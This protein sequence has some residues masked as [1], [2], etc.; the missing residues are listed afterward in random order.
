MSKIRVLLADDHTVLRDGLRSMIDRQPD[1]TVVAEASDARAAVTSCEQTDA[2]VAVLDLAMPE[3][4]G[5]AAIG[6]LRERS[7]RARAIVLTMHDDAAHLRAALDAG[8]AGFVAKRSAGTD[9]LDAIREV[10]AGRGY[11]RAS[12][13][14]QSSLE[15]NAGPTSSVAAL[16]RRERE[17]L[18]LLARGHSNREIAELLGITK[19]TVDTYR[20]R[21]QEKLGLQ[22]RAALVRFALAAGLLAGE[23]PSAG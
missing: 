2:D 8:A 14:P 4:G 21:L 13:G 5:I 10:H 18:A 22:G 6:R 9:L 7:A 15:P 11:V 17:V 1:M 12:L 3:G 16:S 20:L 19:K 23:P